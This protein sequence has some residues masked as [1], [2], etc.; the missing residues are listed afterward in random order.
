MSSNSAGDTALYI[1]T[2][3][4]A[5]D[6]VAA[7]VEAE[8]VGIA[9]ACAGAEAA[10]GTDVGAREVGPALKA[11]AGPCWGPRVGVRVFLGGGIVAFIG[12]GAAVG[13]GAAGRGAIVGSGADVRLGFAGAGDGVRVASAPIAIGD[14]IRVK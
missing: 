13:L 12:F 7:G 14:T 9:E 2:E 8:V 1:Q 10:A 11:T 3:S 4:F 5:A 6:A